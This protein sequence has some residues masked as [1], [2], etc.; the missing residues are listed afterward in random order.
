MT[1]SEN[2]PAGIT[3]QNLLDAGLHFGHQTKRWNPKMKRYIF[4]KRNGIHVLD[5]TQ[6]LMRL[7]ESLAFI[8]ETVLA[9]RKLLF[10][11]TKKQAQSIIKAAADSSGMFC[12]TH[13][14]LGGTLTNSATIARSVRTMRE[15]EKIEKDNYAGIPKQEASTKRREL[16]KLRRNL[17]GIAGM[18]NLP[19]A[20]I[21]VDVI[22]E[23]IAVAEANRMKI[24]IIALVDTN[25]DP[26]PIQYVIPGNDD[27]MRAVKLV[28]ETIAS[29]AKQAVDDAAKVAA[30]RAKEAQSAQQSAPAAASDAPVAEPVRKPARGRGTR[31]PK[32]AVAEEKKPAEQ[33]TAPVVAPTPAAEP[34]PETPAAAATAAPVVPGDEALDEVEI[35][36]PDVKGG[37]LIVRKHA[38]KSD[39]DI[40]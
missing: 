36:D 13:R 37:K 29:V 10:V 35:D 34:K 23:A 15:L 31:K 30:A 27:A 11:G 21:V 17:S 20:L 22:R 28:I 16:E 4:Q 5:L 18:T 1:T 8:R 33:V 38:R 9:G 39:E 12:V 26:D 7:H 25:C 14:W 19:G 3:I 6:T 2:A 32:V 40:E 24:P